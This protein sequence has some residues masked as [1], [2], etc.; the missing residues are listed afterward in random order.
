MCHSYL[1]LL[2]VNHEQR[3]EVDDDPGAGGGEGQHLEGVGRQQVRQEVG[4][5]VHAS[6]VV[7]HGD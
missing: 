6:H 7:A 5:V 2:L 4:A 3:D 1:L